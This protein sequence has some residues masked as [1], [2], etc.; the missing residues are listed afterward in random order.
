MFPNAIVLRPEKT[1]YLLPELVDSLLVD[2]LPNKVILES[3]NFSLISSASSQLSAQVSKDRDVQLFTTFRSNAYQ[4]INI[5]RKQLGLLKFTYTTGSLPL[6]QGEY[7]AFQKK[8]IARFGKSPGREAIKG[9]DLTMDVLLKTAYRGSM[10]NTK[11]I[12]ETQY[13]E[14]RFLY[15]NETPNSYINGGYFML[16]HSGYDILEIKK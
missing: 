14:N 6:K 9:Y 15:V 11:N 10:E 8:Y 1:G 13:E 5:P 16:Q 2:S 3:Q 4:N 12:G 7:N